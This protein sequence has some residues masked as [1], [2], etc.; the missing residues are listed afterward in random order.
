MSPPAPLGAVGRGG[1]A[2]CRS[3]EEGEEAYRFSASRDYGQ[4]RVRTRDRGAPGPRQIDSGTRATLERAR[5]FGVSLPGRCAVSAGV[6]LIWVAREVLQ[7]C[8]TCLS[9]AE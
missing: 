7:S 8:T 3:S 1:S 6:E 4:P 9:P 5:R 2:R